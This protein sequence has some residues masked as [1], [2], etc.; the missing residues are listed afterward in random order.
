MNT[1]VVCRYSRGEIVK[2]TTNFDVAFKLIKRNLFRG[3]TRHTMTTARRE[4]TSRRQIRRSRDHS[5][6]R[7][8]PLV[9]I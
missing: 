2:H 4:V 1:F 3:A 7:F 6:N 5:F 9:F 8:E